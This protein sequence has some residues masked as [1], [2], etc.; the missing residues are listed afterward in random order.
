VENK[1]FANQLFR[2]VETQYKNGKFL[3]PSKRPKDYRTPS[4]SWAA[5]DAP[6]G[7]RCGETRDEGNLLIMV[8]EV[9]V[10]PQPQPNS[11]FGLVKDAD[12]SNS[13]AKIH[14]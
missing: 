6:Q 10:R 14:K 2:C 7:I 3:Y 11:Q 8:T 4:F 1:Y 5:I 9:D 13:N 12:P